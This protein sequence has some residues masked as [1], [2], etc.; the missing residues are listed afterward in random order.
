LFPY[1]LREEDPEE[2][3]LEI[4]IFRSTSKSLGQKRVLF[5]SINPTKALKGARKGRASKQGKF[6]AAEDLKKHGLPT[7]LLKYTAEKGGGEP[8]RG[9][10]EIFEPFL[11]KRVILSFK[12][13][14]LEARESSPR[15]IKRPS[16]KL[17]E[18]NNQNDLKNKGT[19]LRKGR[20]GTIRGQRRLGGKEDLKKRSVGPRASLPYEGE[21]GRP[22]L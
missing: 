13:K 11:K 15:F 9:K 14:G 7:V 16:G 3:V 2:G 6:A 17:L 20:R 18:G 1:S 5:S 8:K 21:E 4:N 22:V 12:R 10:R 19:V